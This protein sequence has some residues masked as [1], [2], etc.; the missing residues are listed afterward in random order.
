MDGECVDGEQVAI[1]VRHVDS[2]LNN[3]VV[4]GGK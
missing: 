4:K 3:F 2:P 1:E